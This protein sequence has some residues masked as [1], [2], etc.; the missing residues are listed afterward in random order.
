MSSP[1]SFFF[2]YFAYF[3]LLCTLVSLVAPF[4]Y[5]ARAENATGSISGQVSRDSDG[6]GLSN[7][8]VIVL[9][10][11]KSY[12][13]ETTTNSSGDYSFTSLT[14]GRYYLCVYNSIPYIGEYYNNVTTS[15]LATPIDVTAGNTV[16]NINFSLMTYGSISGRVTRDADGT[17]IPNVSATAYSSDGNH[18]AST[19][20]SGYYTIEGLTEGYYFVRTSVSPMD[21]SGFGFVS[22]ICGCIPVQVK[23]Q[24]Y[25]REQFLQL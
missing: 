6:L 7:I 3:I 20:S 10:S 24:A 17:G 18:S 8:R 9:D 19:D 2:A 13:T 12:R 23:R 25:D 5:S 15:S 21:G 11:N 14:P 22:K 1:K 16:N 4:Q